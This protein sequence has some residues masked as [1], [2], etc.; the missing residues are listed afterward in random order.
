MFHS[1]CKKKKSFTFFNPDNNSSL[2]LVKLAA[3]KQITVVQ[4]CALTA[5]LQTLT[6]CN[7]FIFVLDVVRLSLRFMLVQ[8]N[9][10]KVNYSSNRSTHHGSCHRDPPPAA[11]SSADS[12]WN[13]MEYVMYI[14]KFYH[15]AFLT[16]QVFFRKWV[17]KKGNNKKN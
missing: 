7:N 15:A 12:T 5:I 4:I 3:Y 11:P 9:K 16:F 17:N 10:H 8:I 2:R 13:Y 14:Y 6:E 1:H